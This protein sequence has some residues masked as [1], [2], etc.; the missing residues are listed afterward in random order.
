VLERFIHALGV[1]RPAIPGD[2]DERAELYRGLT[3]DRRVL[4]VLD[5]AADERQVRPLL[6]GSAGCGVIVTSRVRL[7]GL[8]GAQVETLDGFASGTALALLAKVTGPERVA[9]EPAAAERVVR[10]CGHLPLAV[11]IAG[12]RLAARPAWRLA[13][14]A[15]RL[16]DERRLLDELAVGDLEV[17]GSIA[18]SYQLLDDARRRLFR[19]LGHLPGL[20]FPGWVAMPLAGASPDTAERLIESLV[21]ARLV[22]AVRG[23]GPGSTRYRLHDLLRVYARERS[24]VDDRAQDVHAALGRL[25]GAWLFLAERADDRLGFAQHLARI[26]RSEVPRWPLDAATAGRVVR[27]PLAWMEQER[28]GLVAAVL[29]AAELGMGDIAWDLAGCLTRFL[30]GRWHVDDWRLTLEAALRGAR[31]AGDRRGEASTLRAIGEL[32]MDHDRYEEALGHLRTAAEIFAGCGDERGRAHVRRAIGVAHRMLGRLDT[33]FVCLRETLP[34]FEDHADEPG[35]ACALYSLAAVHLASG[36]P[37]EALAAYERARDLFARLGDAHNEANVLSGMG[38]TLHALGRTADAEDRFRESLALCHDHGLWS[39]EMF[40]RASLGALH[41]DTGDLR[42]ADG[43]LSAALAIS[44]E[45]GDRFGTAL[46]LC[47]LGELRRRQ[48]RPGE[49]DDHV[50][51]AHALYPPIRAAAGSGRPAALPEGSA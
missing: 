9:A 6:P 49:A 20:D 22:E 13:T 44:E 23:D 39:G 48:G 10:L 41:T 36:R 42:S 19:L 17:R 2:P 35:L 40:A 29:H 25:Y 51:R 26:G 45:F 12:A 38:C 11:R 34:V 15:E 27:D 18:L 32:H 3:A 47:N 14:F 8:E 31:T 24:A 50:R 33:A 21:E 16:S 43:E 7:S 37:D 28:A 30:Q 5:N 4:V 1:E 46:A